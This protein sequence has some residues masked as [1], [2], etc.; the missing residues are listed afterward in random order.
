MGGA[1]ADFVVIP[2]STEKIA[3]VAGL[4]IDRPATSLRQD[5]SVLADRCCTDPPILFLVRL[6]V[7]AL[8]RNCRCRQAATASQSFILSWLS[9][10]VSFPFSSL[11]C[12][13][14]VETVTV[15]KQ[16]QQPLSFLSFIPCL[17]L[18]PASVLLLIAPD[19]VS[20]FV[21]PSARV[22]SAT[23][24]KQQQQQQEQKQHQQKRRTLRC[25]GRAGSKQRKAR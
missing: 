24:A 19:S 10:F 7:R 17:S 2:I 4:C 5:F 6:G 13:P 12:F 9:I 22:E 11:L 18:L 20:M 15:A 25:S 21:C 3:D 8:R 1:A 14:R 23:V 16:Q